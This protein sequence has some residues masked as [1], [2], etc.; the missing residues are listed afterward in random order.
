M[1]RTSCNGFLGHATKYGVAQTGVPSE[2]TKP[3]IPYQ[4]QCYYYIVA[5]LLLSF[6]IMLDLCHKQICK[7]IQRLATI[8]LL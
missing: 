6:E 7:N 3:V 1:K 8:L 4:Q 5:R 2:T